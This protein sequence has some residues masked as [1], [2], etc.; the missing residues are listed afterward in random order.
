MSM[1]GSRLACGNSNDIDHIC[2]SSM[3]IPIILIAAVAVVVEVLIV[4]KVILLTVRVAV[5]LLSSGGELF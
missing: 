2:S 5:N 1:N 4:G 3:F